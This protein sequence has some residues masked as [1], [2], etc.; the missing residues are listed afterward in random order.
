MPFVGG[1]NTHIANPRWRAAAIVKNLKIAISRPRFDRFRPNF[2]RRCSSALFSR[3]TVTNSKFE[4]SKMAA[5][6]MLKI[7]KIAISLPRFDR[8]QQNLSLGHSS[9][10]LSL[11]TVKIWRKKIQ[12][13]CG[14]HL[15]KSKNCHISAAVWRSTK[16]VTAIGLG[17]TDFDE[18]CHSEAFPPFWLIRPLNFQCSEIQD[19]GVCRLE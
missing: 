2:A 4:I 7:R 11:P 18:I 15:K 5:A 8:L 13:G 17:L 9:A 19:G 16:L 14:R 1:P 12:D 3:P 6:A 10:L